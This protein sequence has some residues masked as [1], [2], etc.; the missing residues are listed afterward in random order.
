MPG[1]SVVA[2]NGA[3]VVSPIHRNGIQQHSSVLAY[4]AVV[5]RTTAVSRC[6]GIV[7]TT[8]I[9]LSLATRAGTGPRSRQRLSERNRR[10]ACVNQ[11][12]RT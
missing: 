1:R 3:T 7:V 12:I 4:L 5:L 10:Y 2:T 11:R 8:I 6:L 9:G